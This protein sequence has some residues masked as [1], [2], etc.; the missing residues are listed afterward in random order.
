M[1]KSVHTCFII[2]SQDVST[3]QKLHSDPLSEY[4]HIANQEVTDKIVATSPS[5]APVTSKLLQIAPVTSSATGY[6]IHSCS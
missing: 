4:F 2:K 1:L 3:R 5:V 6:S